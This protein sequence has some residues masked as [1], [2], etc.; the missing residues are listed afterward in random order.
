MTEEK[1]QVGQQGSLKVAMIRITLHHDTLQE[2]SHD[3]KHN[4][5]ILN[6]DTK[7]LSRRRR[8]GSWTLSASELGI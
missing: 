2:A 5:D 3:P 1:E 6:K 8:T 7:V 4:R